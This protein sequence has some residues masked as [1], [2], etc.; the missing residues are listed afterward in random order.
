MAASYTLNSNGQVV[1]S[2]ALDVP[3]E[4]WTAEPITSIGS[5]YQARAII[6]GTEEATTSGVFEEW[7]SLSSNTTWGL[8]NNGGLRFTIQIRSINSAAILASATIQLGLFLPN[9]LPAPLYTFV[10]APV[11]IVTNDR[12]GWCVA[13]ARGTNDRIA[14]TSLSTSASRASDL[15]VYLRNGDRWDLEYR[16]TGIAGAFRNFADMVW[17]S[18][19]GSMM[20]ST[21]RSGATIFLRYYTRTGVIW[22]L[23]STVDTTMDAN[24]GA[25]SPETNICASGDGSTVVVFGTV[26]TEIRVYRLTGSTYSQVFLVDTPAVD[27][28]SGVAISRDGLRFGFNGRYD[29]F[30]YQ[31]DGSD[32]WTLLDTI[33]RAS[34]GGS[35]EERSLDLNSNGDLLFYR[36]LNATSNTEI[37]SFNGLAYALQ[38][39]IADTSL[40]STID[41]GA[42]S[43]SGFTGMY[44]S[45]SSSNDW[46]RGLMQIIQSNGTNYEIVRQLRSPSEPNDSITALMSNDGAM[47]ICGRFND[48]IRSGIQVYEAT[49]QD[50]VTG[51]ILNDTA[52]DI[53]MGSTVDSTRQIATILGT[54]PSNGAL[55]TCY[56]SFTISDLGMFYIEFTPLGSVSSSSRC[57]FNREGTYTP[58]SPMGAGSQSIGISPLGFIALQGSQTFDFPAFGVGDIVAIA[59][60]KST[61]TILIDCYLNNVFI[62]QKSFSGST[63]IGLIPGVTLGINTEIGSSWRVFTSALNQNFT[64]PPGFVPLEQQVL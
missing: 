57:G 35:T 28:G 63:A 3:G 38:D 2:D 13:M 30:I 44:C 5:F 4:W 32:N 27:S 22:T 29:T 41:M 58:S 51:L 37:W 6:T 33:D 9:W 24:P 11:D 49:G 39:S 23:Q 31:N 26:E 52:N 60:D 19:D 61:G 21:D 46:N 62:I 53:N 47:G 40:D 59:V 8:T 20:W 50:E 14:C 36:P 16:E 45:P 42:F 56:T 18:D 15:F 10:Y 7:V 17:M 55:G 43:S 12:F 54:E 25:A 34:V 48:G 1:R 64:P